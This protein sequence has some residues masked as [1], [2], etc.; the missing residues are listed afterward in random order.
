MSSV[1]SNPSKSNNTRGDKMQLF[2]WPTVKSWFDDPKLSLSYCRY[3]AKCHGE[4][5]RS[6]VTQSHGWCEQCQDT[7][8]V[9]RCKVPYWILAATLALLW[10][11]HF[12][13]T[14]RR[15]WF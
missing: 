3:C 9:T 11:V 13:S 8:E 7:V 5:S 4:V 10:F 1:D 14:L 15:Y 6:A 12:N 2:D